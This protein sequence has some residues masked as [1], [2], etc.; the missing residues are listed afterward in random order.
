MTRTGSAA[1]QWKIAT[2]QSLRL[3]RAQVMAI[4]NVTPDSFSD[5]GRFDSPDAVVR[6]AREAVEQGA[7]LLDIGGEST[8]PGAEAVSASEQI[9]RVIPAIEGIRA[10]GIKAPIS[11][12]TTS[13]AVAEAALG[14]G[15]Q[16]IDDVSAGLDDGAMLQ[17]AADHGAGIILMHRLA[18]PRDD[19]WS[20]AYASDPAYPGGVVPCVLGF[21]L[22]RAEAAM[23]AGIRREAIAID[24][25]LGFGK[26]V[27]QNFELIRS[28]AAFAQTGFPVLGAA[29]RK[30]FLGAVTGIENPA[31]RVEASIAASV[32]Q[33]LAGAPLF[34]VHDVAAQASALRAADAIL[35]QKPDQE[36]G[37]ADGATPAG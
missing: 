17:L 29:S 19:S 35:S 27:A 12:D 14:A 13:A 5:G 34:R 15:A 21:L 24:P 31:E 6:A 7:D 37:I 26:S 25:G 32:A 4:L 20:D 3:G 22:E 16:I 1:Q 9:R 23:G 2:D 18:K 8:R 33:R 30:S 28:T 36:P 10:A 11:V